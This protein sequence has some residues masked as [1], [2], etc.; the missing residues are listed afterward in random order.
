MEA[1]KTKRYGPLPVGMMVLRMNVVSSAE[2][3]ERIANTV[4]VSQ[5]G[6]FVPNDRGLE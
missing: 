3:V 4:S 2:L 5:T 6:C 1:M